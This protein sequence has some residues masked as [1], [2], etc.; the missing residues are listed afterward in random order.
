M[1]DVFKIPEIPE[2]KAFDLA[3]WSRDNTAYQKWM[4]GPREPLKD[5]TMFPPMPKD[6]IITAVNVLEAMDPS[7]SKFKWEAP[8][9][10][11]K[12]YDFP[13]PV[14]TYKWTKNEPKPD[15]VSSDS[16]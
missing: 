6:Y 10:E 8:K 7:S 11:K 9:V 5:R 2:G 16:E 4:E 14:I 1:E 3:R 15:G 12:T 13:K